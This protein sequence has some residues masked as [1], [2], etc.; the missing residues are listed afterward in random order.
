MKNNHDPPPDRERPPAMFVGDDL[1]ESLLPAPVQETAARPD[2]L[3]VVIE[4]TSAGRLL[5]IAAG[6]LVALVLGVLGTNWISPDGGAGVANYVFTGLG[7]AV[8]AWLANRDLV[9]RRREFRLLD[10]GITVTVQPLTGGPPRTADIPWAEIEDYTVTDEPGNAFLHVVSVRGYTLTLKD[11]PPCSSTREFIR[12][13]V[14]QADR[15]PRAVQATPRAE[16]SRLPDVTGERAPALGGCAT[17]LSFVLL[18]SAVETFLD[19]SLA[20]KVSG[21]AAVALI[22]MVVEFWLDLI[23]TETAGHDE[24]SNRLIARLRRW[25]RRVLRIRIE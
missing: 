10:G 7:V 13:F 24:E 25:M 4:R 8:L 23:D 2:D 14:E 5:L 11:R 12:R 1:P 18:T 22:F 6:L 20:Q 19:P 3:R 9:R 15:Y 21:V 16:G 17:M